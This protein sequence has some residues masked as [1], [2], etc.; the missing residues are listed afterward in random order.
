MSSR[1]N[2]AD[3]GWG[4]GVF[5]RVGGGVDVGSGVGG[6]TAGVGPGVGV[7]VW[8]VREGRVVDV[9]WGTPVGSRVAISEAAAGGRVAD[10]DGSGCGVSAPPQAIAVSAVMREM[11]N[12]AARAWR[13]IVLE[14]RKSE[15]GMIDAYLIRGKGFF[16]VGGERFSS[17]MTRKRA[18][19][20][21]YI[22]QL[23]VALVNSQV[24]T[25]R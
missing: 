4:I 9:G 16:N 22:F 25:G 11:M 20:R 14:I 21:R 23:I 3:V 17:R 24:G 2:G 10:G 7:G 8:M 6:A 12:S 13:I 15:T 19:R 18:P 1:R 5:V